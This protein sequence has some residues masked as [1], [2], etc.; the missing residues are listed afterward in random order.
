MSSRGSRWRFG[1]AAAEWLRSL[2]RNQR[3]LEKE[4]RTTRKP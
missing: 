1:E 3:R 4:R 2:Y